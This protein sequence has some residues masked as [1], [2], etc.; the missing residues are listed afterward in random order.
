MVGHP[1]ATSSIWASM[2]S[3]SR[4]GKVKEW[5]LEAVLEEWEETFLKAPA[6]LSQPLIGLI[7]SCLPSWTIYNQV[8]IVLTGESPF[9][10]QESSVRFV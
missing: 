3:S 9:W 5:V 7:M 6:N 4:P 10:E 8:K 2:L 1:M